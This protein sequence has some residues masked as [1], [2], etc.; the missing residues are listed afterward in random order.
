MSRSA[1]RCTEVRDGA[2]SSATPKSR[3][4][5]CCPPHGRVTTGSSC[6]GSPTTT[7]RFARQIA[8]AACWGGAAPCLANQQ[9]ADR[10]PAEPA[11]HRGHRRKRRGNDGDNEEQRLPGGQQDAVTRPAFAA[12]EVNERV[13][14]PPDPACLRGDERLVQRERG[15]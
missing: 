13:Q 5:A 14:V 4:S 9:P 6:M 1:T 10:F 12:E 11:E 8:P 7:V 3:S 2:H 15:E